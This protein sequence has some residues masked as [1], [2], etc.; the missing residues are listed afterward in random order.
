MSAFLKTWNG[1]L[2][3]LEKDLAI[4][5]ISIAILR[6]KDG[7]FVDN[8]AIESASTL[9]DYYGKKLNNRNW[10]DTI[11][12]SAVPNEQFRSALEEAVR[13]FSPL[14]K[15]NE[16]SEIPFLEKILSLL[17]KLIDQKGLDEQEIIELLAAFRSERYGL[18]SERDFFNIGLFEQDAS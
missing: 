2:S 8:E 1:S 14:G 15:T 5:M 7:E 4:S 10:G 9:R 6:L 3:P 13:A 18:N 12:E 16:N 11:P 17:G